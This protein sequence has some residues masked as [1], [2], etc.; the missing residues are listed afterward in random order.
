M[1]DL[2]V[3]IPGCGAGRSAAGGQVLASASGHATSHNKRRRVKLYC[4]SA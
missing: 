1:H 3:A 4:V 2:V